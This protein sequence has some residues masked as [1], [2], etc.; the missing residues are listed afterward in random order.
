M[1][2]PWHTRRKEKI[3]EDFEKFAGNWL[4]DY[5]ENP[6]LPAL[7]IINGW[8][9]E[10]NENT[11]MADLMRGEVNYYAYDSR[12]Q[13]NSIKEGRLDAVQ[14]AIDADHI[15]SKQFAMIDDLSHNGNKKILEGHCI[16]TMTIATLFAGKFNIAS[17]IDGVILLSPVSTFSLPNYLKLTYF[18]PQWMATFAIKYLAPP[19]VNKIAPADE[20]EHSRDFAMTRLMRLDYGAA[21]RQ[22]KE[23][24]WK[25][26]VSNYWE[27]INVPALIFVGKND[28]LVKYE[29]SIHPFLNL[30]YPIWVELEAP[31]HLIMES[32]ADFIQKL[33]P[34][35]CRDPWAVYGQYKDRKPMGL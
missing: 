20:S 21:L 2:L 12:G 10:H 27:R 18:V 24:F 16:G 33:I 5:K 35:F 13:G 25:E 6:S 31:D 23:I 17:E 7:A 22:V 30:K 15:L 9:A 8:Q 34:Q 32:N 3:L 11:W 4:S 1:E 26:N 14:N 29:D 28:P 19:I